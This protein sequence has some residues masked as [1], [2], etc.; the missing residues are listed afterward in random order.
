MGM[1]DR[2]RNGREKKCKDKRTRKQTSRTGI[3][4]TRTS[5]IGRWT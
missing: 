4:R 2:Y 3:R 1:N 5:R